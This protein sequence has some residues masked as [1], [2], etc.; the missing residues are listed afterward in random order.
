MTNTKDQMQDVFPISFKIE[1]GE[2]PTAEKLTGWIKQTD[3]GFSRI[4]R[5]VGDPWEYSS[6]I[7]GD[8][9][10]ERLAQ[11]SLARTIGPSDYLSPRGSSFQEGNSG[12]VQLRL[13]GGRN[14]WNIGFPLVKLNSDYLPS[15]SGTTMIDELVWTVDLVLDTAPSGYFAYW[16]TTIE[17]VD[18]PGSFHIDNMTGTITSFDAPPSPVYITVKN[19]HMLGPGVPW[20]TSN[21]IPHWDSGSL[22]TVSEIS[23]GGGQTQYTVE[24]PEVAAGSRQAGSGISGLGS[25]LQSFCYGA[26]AKHR[27]PVSLTSKFSTGD[28]IPEGFIYIWEDATSRIVP[29]T[30]SYYIDANSLKVITPEGW[31]TEGATVR[32][33]T[34]GSSAAESIHYLSSVVRE[35]NHSGLTDGLLDDTLHYT[36]PITHKDLVGNYSGE[37][38]S[39]LVDDYKF[40]FRKS[41]YPTNDHPQYLHRAGYLV[42][43]KD[44]NTANAMRG[45][46]V[47]AGKYNGSD[48]ELGGGTSGGNMKNTYGLMFGGGSDSTTAENA[49]ISWEG[50]ADISTWS[51]PSTPADVLA[52]GVTEVGAQP[53]GTERYGALA[54][55]PWYGMPLYIKGVNSTQSEYIGAVLGFDFGDNSELNYIKLMKASRSGAYDQRHQPAR[56]SQTVSTVLDITPSLDNASYYSRLAPEQI[57]EFRFRG[58][59]FNTDARNSDDGIGGVAGT[60]KSLSFDVISRGGMSGTYVISGEHAAAFMPGKTMVVSGFTNS[61][62]NGTRNIVAV[63][64]HSGNTYITPS[65]GSTVD[66]TASATAVLDVNEFHPYFTSPGMIG[67]DF[68][69]V[70]SNAIFFSDT[71]DGK[72]TS[73]TTLGTDWLNSDS[74][75]PTGMY[76]VPPNGSEGPHF[77]Y[78]IYDSNYSASTNPLSVGDRE[79]FVYNSRNEGPILM[80][81]ENSFAVLAG[82]AASSES[83]ID[84]FKS[85][86]S[87]QIVL[88]NDVSSAVRANLQVG[89]YGI[90]I[91]ADDNLYLGA[92]EDLTIEAQDSFS[93]LCN[94][95]SHISYGDTSSTSTT[96]NDIE[97]KAARL[98]LQYHS[99][100]QT[101]PDE[102]S[103]LSLGSSSS[104]LYSKNNLFLTA[105]GTMEINADAVKILSLPVL[106]PTNR[107]TL[108]INTVTGE[109]GTAV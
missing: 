95:E 104:T 3:T 70:Y 54:Y 39:S 76:F 51:N 89:N 69:N 91:I 61:V 31:L 30:T 81:S 44:G 32:I 101:D 84:D 64:S 74:N 5:A 68:V 29:L 13:D 48:F 85:L 98:L 20:G 41:D 106:L 6:H 103:R 88:V 49:R 55:T 82:S 15:S 79:G 2:M 12:E 10:P 77:D 28:T 86:A 72:V 27:L 50:G 42:D 102:Y 107:Q 17:G 66:E 34:S 71:G 22:C 60:D 56:I 24:L 75:R 25:R 40:F 73:Y 46:I 109:I 58:C 26:G 14:V 94:E 93:I 97:L 100:G 65:G 59:S 87:G 90:Q 63:S 38:S 8:L 80:A 67:A 18:S 7:H 47:F 16:S 92:N 45:H 108:Y 57:R 35:N 78:Y 53:Y 33:I 1:R 52:F 105:V 99:A 21:V 43:D 4:T 19:L 9:S 37:I 36:R 23:S 11:T 96:W 83:T 62:N